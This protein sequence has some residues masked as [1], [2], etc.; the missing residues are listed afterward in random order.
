MKRGTCWKPGA[1]SSLDQQR[2]GLRRTTQQHQYFAASFVLFDS[3]S[4]EILRHPIV[5][6]DAAAAEQGNPPEV[7]RVVPIV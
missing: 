2:N 4:I 7:V 1:S 3:E 6:F 5:L